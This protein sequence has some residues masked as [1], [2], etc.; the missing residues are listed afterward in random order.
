MNPVHQDTKNHQAHKILN[1]QKRV[2]ELEADNAKLRKMSS[3]S[4]TKV[5]EISSESEDDKSGNVQ[6]NLQIISYNNKPPRSKKFHEIIAVSKSKLQQTPIV[7]DEALFEIGQNYIDKMDIK[8]NL[9]RVEK[10]N[11]W[12]DCA[13]CT[14][15]LW[16][17]LENKAHYQTEEKILEMLV[18]NVPLMKRNL[19]NSEDRK[20][21]IS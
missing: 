9:Q 14:L 10:S 1:L 21:R 8:W 3:S 13:F 11:Y 19:S 6:F 15:V 4:C 2:L 5:F 12:G 18:D 20:L 7:T 16:I 17:L